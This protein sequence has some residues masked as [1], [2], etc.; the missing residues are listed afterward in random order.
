MT[1]EPRTLGGS[2]VGAGFSSP[3][4]ATEATT[5][6][7]DKNVTSLKSGLL[8]LAQTLP[9]GLSHH[10]PPK[11]GHASNRPTESKRDYA[12]TSSRSA[13]SRSTFATSGPLP[14]MPGTSS[15]NG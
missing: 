8:V 9:Q 13:F 11:W 3:P 12:P 1:Q 2:A 4:Q 10:K 7:A 15:R 14:S 5:T 6:S